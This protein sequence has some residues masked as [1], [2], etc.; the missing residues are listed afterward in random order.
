MT[1]PRVRRLLALV[2]LAAGP[3][4]VLGVLFVLPVAG[5]IAEGFV[6]DGRF[7]PGAVLD[8]LARPRVRRV[9]WFTVWTSGLATVC[10]GCQATASTHRP[11]WRPARQ[12]CVT[13]PR[14]GSPIRAAPGR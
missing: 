5:M 8:V 14:M 10:N 3:V 4:L 7:A 13:S 1:A 11:P 12:E 2:L 6:V 9:A